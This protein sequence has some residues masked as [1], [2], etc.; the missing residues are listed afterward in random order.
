M[1]KK[2]D[3]SWHMTS[4]CP[5]QLWRKRGRNKIVLIVIGTEGNS[6]KNALEEKWNVYLEG[7]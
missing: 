6:E 7:R 5:I 1:R 4:I 2:K 3:S